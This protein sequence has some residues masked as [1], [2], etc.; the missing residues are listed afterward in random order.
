M[1]PA[2]MIGAIDHASEN[3]SVKGN[4]NEPENVSEKENA[5]E[6]ENVVQGKLSHK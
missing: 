6:I 1:T 4:A 5:K 2:G 3:E